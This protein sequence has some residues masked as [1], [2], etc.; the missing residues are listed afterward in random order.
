MLA[1]VAAGKTSH[2]VAMVLSIGRK[3]V[4][5]HLWNIFAKIDVSSRT[6]SAAYAFAYD[7]TSPARG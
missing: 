7:L 4:A 1:L 6:K 5:R 2:E 3:T